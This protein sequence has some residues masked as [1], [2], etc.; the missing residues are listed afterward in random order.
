MI[1][2]KIGAAATVRC[3]SARPRR[4]SGSDRR[5]GDRVHHPSLRLDVRTPTSSSP[6]KKARPARRASLP[7]LA[8]RGRARW[9]AFGPLSQASARSRTLR[10]RGRLAVERRSRCAVHGK[11]LTAVV[12]VYSPPAYVSPATSAPRRRH[13][14]DQDTE[15]PVVAWS[16][17]HDL[18]RPALASRLS[19][20]RRLS[21]ALSRTEQYDLDHFGRVSVKRTSAPARSRRAPSSGQQAARFRRRASH[22]GTFTSLQASRSSR[23]STSDPRDDPV[24]RRP[25]LS[26]TPRATHLPAV[27]HG[28]TLPPR[29]PLPRLRNRSARTRS[30]R[31]P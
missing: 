17:T 16:G 21:R 9:T 7:R 29:P 22:A 2:V 31:I 8:V 4:P 12:P 30:T 1:A 14:Q 20:R 23:A 3:G 28:S 18:H 13:P 25:R 5:A 10:E 19:G 26:S 24:C 11:G 27:N 15:L 6:I